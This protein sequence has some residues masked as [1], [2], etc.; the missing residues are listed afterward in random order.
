MFKWRPLKAPAIIGTGLEVRYSIGIIMKTRFICAYMAYSKV[1][2]AFDPATK[3]G[4]KT[5]EP[6]TS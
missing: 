5:T 4:M 2:A 1:R 6:V 3:T